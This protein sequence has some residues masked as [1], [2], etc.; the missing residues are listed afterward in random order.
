MA[1]L[2]SLDIGG[3]ERLVTDWAIWAKETGKVEPSI[4]V[5][6]AVYNEQFLAELHAKNVDVHI[7]HRAPGSS[8]IGSMLVLQFLIFRIRP[9]IIHVHNYAAGKA[10]LCLHIL[11]LWTGLFWTVH[12]TNEVYSYSPF[13]LWLAKLYRVRFLAISQAVADECLAVGLTD[14]T[15]VYNGIKIERFRRIFRYRPVGDPVKLVCV[16]R[17]DCVHKGQDVL[18]RALGKCVAGGMN[19]QCT[20]VGG[21]SALCSD[22][23][24]HLKNLAAD[25]GLSN[26]VEFY[27]DRSDA[28]HFLDAGDIFVLPTRFEGFGLAVVEAMAAGLPV[29][30]SN[31]DGL[32]EIIRDGETGFFAR[33]GDEDSLA[34]KIEEVVARRDLEP[35]CRAA[36]QRAEAFTME[37]MCEN[38]LAAYTVNGRFEAAS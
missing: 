22:E 19:V 4:V 34:A 18:L 20:F 32:K 14:V 27:L 7:L 30:V 29:I 38:Y 36:A 28:E 2:P 21:P 24:K 26:R 10:I 23:L 17:L 3:A 15:V 37:R 8:I 9:D 11:A 1:V 33:K 25:M 13:F 16:A 35:I 31:V 6:N 5:I 12:S